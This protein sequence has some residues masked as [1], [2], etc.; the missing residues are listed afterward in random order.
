MTAPALALIMTAAGL[1]RFTAAQVEDDID[2]TVAS[3]GLTAADF[4]LAPTLTALPGEFR[5]VETLS[6]ATVGDNIVHMIVRDDEEIGYTVRGFGL[7]LADGTLFAV[8]GQ[9]TPICEKSP[10]TTLLMP[11][12][13]AFPTSAIDNLVFGDTNFLNPPA[14]TAR[15]G[16]IEIAT[17]TEAQAGDTGRAVTG[18]VVKAM[19]AA[20]A[21]GTDDDLAAL[22]AAFQSMIDALLARTIT[23]SGLV[24]GGGTL[25]ANRMLDV[26]AATSAECLAGVSV[27][28]AVTPAALA[29]AGIIYLVETKSA[30]SSRYRRFSDGRVEMSGVS[31]LPMSE[32]VFDLQFPWPFP[33]VCEGI[34]ST[35]INGNLTND[36]QSTVQEVLLDRVHATLFAQNHK[37]P[38]VDASGGF[39]WFAIGR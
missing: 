24:T 32:V 7:F 10:Q 34:W 33:T 4:V 6:G 36:G 21:S 16:I 9:P 5:R 15:R 2:L 18:A 13:I 8:Y 1:N 14:T 37:T 26:T 28:H 35:I 20:Q 29:D 3:V 17:L 19:L 31:A 38:T 39:R 27:D 11:L 25:A 12:D 23:G 30:G 22:S